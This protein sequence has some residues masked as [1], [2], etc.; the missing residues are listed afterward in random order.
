M[1]DSIQLDHYSVGGTLIT[2]VVALSIF[3]QGKVKKKLG[4]ET[5]QEFHEV[6][7]VYMSAVGTLY[8]VLLGL[9]VVDASSRFNQARDSTLNEANYLMEVFALAE[10]APEPQ[11][12]SIKEGL[13][14]YVDFVLTE[15]WDSMNK[16]EKNPTELNLFRNIMNEVRSVEPVTEN[17][18]TVYS[19]LLDAFIKASE[20]RRSR[21]NFDQ[22]NIP[23]VEWFSLI[24]GGII[25]IAFTM[26]FAIEH[27]LAQALMTGMVTFILSLNLFIAYLYNTPYTGDLSVKKDP[28][29][30]LQK[31]THEPLAVT[32]SKLRR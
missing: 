2:I 32:P 11:R 18:K 27:K 3:I 10:R 19:A 17:Q 16:G 8:A 5:L 20:S 28:F 26:F 31:F 14:T 1:L 24:M 13:R 22:Y 12:Q 29:L 7:S 23:T 6:G 21:L 30:S 9:V 25:T 15:G 4:K